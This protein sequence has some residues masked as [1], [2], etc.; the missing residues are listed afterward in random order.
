MKKTTLNI[1]EEDF[2]E[3]S[4]KAKSFSGRT[5]KMIKA[6]NEVEDEMGLDSEFEN[7]DLV[8]LKTYIN[9]I[10]KNISLLKSKRNK[11]QERVDEIEENENE[12]VLIEVEIDLEGKRY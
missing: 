10:E 12:D 5:R 2:E 6:C 7:M 3:F 1:P 9:A 4:E 8:V 11:L